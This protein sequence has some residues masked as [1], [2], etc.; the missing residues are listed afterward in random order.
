M[1]LCYLTWLG[2]IAAQKIIHFGSVAG[3]GYGWT[4]TLRQIVG[5]SLSKRA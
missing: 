5:G 4:N 2:K 1:N 3:Q